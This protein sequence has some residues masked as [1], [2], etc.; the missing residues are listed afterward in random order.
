LPLFQDCVYD[1]N[2]NSSATLTVL[3]N[4]ETAPGILENPSESADHIKC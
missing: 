1:G 4:A 3:N 2:L